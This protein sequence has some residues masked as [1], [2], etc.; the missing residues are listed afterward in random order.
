[1]AALYVLSRPVSS[2]INIPILPQILRW[3]T[4]YRMSRCLF[5][6]VLRAL[7]AQ[8]ALDMPTTACFSGALRKKKAPWPQRLTSGLMS[9]GLYGLMV[10]QEQA[11]V[12]FSRSGKAAFLT[13]LLQ[14]ARTFPWGWFL[15]HTVF[16]PRWHYITSERTTSHEPRLLHRAEQLQLEQT[17]GYVLARSA[18][19][20]VGN[21]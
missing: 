21:W 5:P 15:H 1:M 12:S 3:K 14:S 17:G 6:V 20:E 13:L 2:Q 19:Y 18:W 7:S 16:E 11:G 9:L 10:D 4:R 8:I